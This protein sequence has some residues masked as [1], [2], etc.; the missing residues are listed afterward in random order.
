MKQRRWQLVAAALILAG[1]AP[2]GVA[3]AQFTG[4]P[5]TPR[6]LDDFLP[7]V[8]HSVSTVD[9]FTGLVAVALIQGT[10]RD[11][12]GNTIDFELDVRAMQGNY[13]DRNGNSQRGSFSFT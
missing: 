13:I 12:A 7:R 5:A 4:P 10:G 8:G 2:A 3:Q 1:L 6:P 11:G 9:N